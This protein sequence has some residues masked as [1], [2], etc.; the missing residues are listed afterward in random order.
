MNIVY[1]DDRNEYVTSCIMHILKYENIAIFGAARGGCKLAEMLQQRSNNVF[2][3]DNSK[4]K[5]GNT[6]NGIKIHNPIYIKKF[7]ANNTIVVITC[8]QVESVKRQVSS[9]FDGEVMQLDIAWHDEIKSFEKYYE[10][11]LDKFA[12]CYCLLEDDLSRMTYQ[13]VLN[14]R[15]NHRAYFL[16]KVISSN[17]QYFDIDIVKLSKNEVFIDGGAYNGDTTDLFLKFT[18]S[19]FDKV[20]CFEPYHGNVLKLNER[21]W[22]GDSRINI[23]EAA[24]GKTRG[25]TKL[26][27]LT[28]NGA[29]SCFTS[30]DGTENIEIVS[31]DE[32][33]SEKVT[34]VKLDIEGDEIKALLGMQNIIKIYKPKLAI[35]LYHSYEDLADIPIILKA[36]NPSYKIYVRHYSL[37]AFETICYAIEED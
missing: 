5:Q 19:C 15:I 37:T 23:I 36:I 3:L 21:D 33:I 29:S 8:A 20:L 13:A 12:E 1:N 18:E 9:L 10:T 7:T 11:N 16:E 4:E 28:N 25:F 17:E 30:D 31:L 32:F 2:F 35:C 34:F 22:N 24:L 14:Y 26:D 6:F 27:V